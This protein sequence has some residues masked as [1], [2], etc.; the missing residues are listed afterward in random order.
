MPKLRHKFPT[1]RR[2]PERNKAFVVLAGRRV[3]LP[4]K[5][6]SPESRAE[7]RRLCLQWDP[8]SQL[9]APVNSHDLSIAELLVRYWRFAERHY[10]KHGRQTDELPCTKSA[11]KF[12]S[13]LF[14]ELPAA[15]FS[16]VKLKT[17][18]DSM[19]QAGLARTT[20]NIHCSRIRRLFRWAAAEELVSPAVWQSLAAV[21]GLQRGRTT[22]RE[23]EPVLPVED[24]V[25]AATLPHLPPV[26]RDMVNVQRLC[27]MRPME[28]CQ[29]RPCDI[30]NRGEV[31][32]YRPEEW[33]TEH[34]DQSR[35]IFIG[36]QAQAV[37]AP[38]LVDR[39][40]AD[41]V[42]SP[43]ESE[44]G[45]IEDRHAK[46]VTPE[47]YGNTV[48]TNRK[49]RP[50]TRPGDRYETDAYRRAITRACEKAF[51]MPDHLRRIPDDMD[52]DEKQHRRKLA[53]EWRAKHC[54]A[55]NQLRHAA[56]TRIREQ[57]GIES[58]QSV[59]G[60]AKPDMTLVYAER[61]EKLAVEVALRL[62]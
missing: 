59:L 52:A 29:M 11:I 44:Q 20:I 5:Y 6:G 57:F 53:A 18:R 8:D 10:V 17:V 22:A 24:S 36:P 45:R 42:F 54:W 12:L 62:G 13:E 55:P 25:V 33:K 31:W 58:A 40:E 32:K 39:D 34:R 61:S 21:S 14:G 51:G 15:E 2:F 16:P 3:Y 4:G 48:G 9:D 49:R 41:Y 19:V 38:Y 56:A 35:A 28:V 1:Y 46:R 23:P 60:H 47:H 27:G 7:Y 43:A 37:L 30:D 50:K 26:V